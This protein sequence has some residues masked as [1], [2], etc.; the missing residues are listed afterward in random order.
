MT[1]D[2]AFVSQE[3]VAGFSEK[4]VSNSFCNSKRIIVIG[5]FR[6]AEQT[7]I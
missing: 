4:E 1:N 2:Q 6:T 5:W 7:A 3:F